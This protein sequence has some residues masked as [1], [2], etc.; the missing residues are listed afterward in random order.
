M[1]TRSTWTSRLVVLATLLV[2]GSSAIAGLVLQASGVTSNY[3]VIGGSFNRTIDQTGLSQSYIS[4][5]TDFGTY[6]STTTHAG[7]GAGNGV[8]ISFPGG[9]SATYGLGGLKSIDGLAYWGH[10]FG[11]HTQVVEFF[12]DLDNDFSNGTLGSL[13]TITDLAGSSADVLSFASVS[14]SFVHMILQSTS[15]SAPV[16]AEVAFS[17]TQIPE[18]TSLA[19]VG[20][21]LAGLAA[22]RRRKQ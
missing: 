19:L 15:Q 10:Q 6:V 11:G 16:F 9:S 7:V 14:A 18:P 12:A 1:T 21:S 8:Q 13:G 2:S 4:G 5:V 22:T 17:Q 3:T 20:L